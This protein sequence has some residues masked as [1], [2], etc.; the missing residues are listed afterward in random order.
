MLKARGDLEDALSVFDA[1]LAL[2]PEWPD[3]HFARAETLA[4]AGD[5]LAAREGYAAYL[6]FADADVMGAEARLALL[7]AAPT[8]A[9]LPAAY[10]RTLFDQY[11]ERFDEALLTRLE[12]RA[13]YQL[14]AAFDKAAPLAAASLRVLD[15]GCGTGLAGEAFRDRASWLAGVD[16]SPGMVAAA[17]RKRLYD[18]LAVEEAVTALAARPAA[19]DLVVAADVLVYIGDLAPLF[20]AARHALAAGGYICVSTERADAGD[21]SLGR[22]CRYAHGRPY[23]ERLAAETGFEVVLHEDAVCRQE[24][25]VDVPS[26]IAVLRAGACSEA[27]AH[28]ADAGD[29]EREQRHA[30]Q[31]DIAGAAPLPRQQPEHDDG[32]H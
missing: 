20:R 12:Y 10:V 26:R 25:G 28:E 32:G 14:R 17:R 22:G 4:E 15:L 9:S 13:P 2:A 23:I 16:L 31:A 5:T 30:F 19:Y 21:Y 18:S 29:I 24:A 6:R 11:A 1:A 3:A 7:G 27:E 8:P